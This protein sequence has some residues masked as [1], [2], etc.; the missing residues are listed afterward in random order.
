MDDQPTCG[1][2]LAEHATLPAILARLMAATAAILENHQKALVLDDQNARLEHE[3][4][5]KLARAHRDVA[6]RLHRT[7]EQMAGC[8][9]LPMGTHD[10]RAMI[11]AEAFET[12]RE[13]VTKER[14]LLSQLQTAVRRDEMM[15]EQMHKMGR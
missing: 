14:E 8:R 13:F 6:E 3:A 11:S 2:G 12:F 5:A 1:Q 7:A 15:L 10:E 9:D 4:Y